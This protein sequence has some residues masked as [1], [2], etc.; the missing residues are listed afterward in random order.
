MIYMCNVHVYVHAH[1]HMHTCTN[2]QFVHEA[3]YI[4]M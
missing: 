4:D 3:V 1:A 2:V